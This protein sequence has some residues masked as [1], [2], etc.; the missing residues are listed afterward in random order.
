M[1]GVALLL[2]SLL[3]SALCTSN[4]LWTADVLTCADTDSSA[5]S[6]VPAEGFCLVVRGQ[7]QG[8][9]ITGTL[10][11]QGV[12]PT[13]VSLFSTSSVCAP[14]IGDIIE[15]KLPTDGSR[16]SRWRFPLAIP[17]EGA[18]TFHVRQIG[19]FD[20][21][22]FVDPLDITISVSTLHSGVFRASVIDEAATGA[23]T[24]LRV[25]GALAGTP[26]ISSGSESF[27][28][29]HPIAE[30]AKFD[31]MTPKGLPSSAVLIGTTEFNGGL[32]AVCEDGIYAAAAV[33]ILKTTSTGSWYK[34]PVLVDND[35]VFKRI[36][37]SAAQKHPSSPLASGLQLILGEIDGKE[38]VFSIVATSGSLGGFSVIAGCEDAQ[39][40]TMKDGL[41]IYPDGHV[42]NADVTDIYVEAS[43]TTVYVPSVPVV[44]P[45]L[46]LGTLTRQCENA[47]DVGANE[48]SC[49]QLPEGWSSVSVVDGLYVG[50]DRAFHVLVEGPANQFAV[51]SSSP[52]GGWLVLAHTAAQMAQCFGPTWGF[53]HASASFDAAV[54]A[55][56]TTVLSFTPLVLPATLETVEP[57]DHPFISNGGGTAVTYAH[58]S[59][60]PVSGLLHVGGPSAL[61]SVTKSIVT[62]MLH[63]ASM[64]LGRPAFD[65]L[66]QAV[67]VLGDGQ[68][69]GQ[70]VASFNPAGITGDVLL[71]DVGGTR[72]LTLSA[73]QIVA[74]AFLSTQ[75]LVEGLSLDSCQLISF[76]TEPIMASR[77]TRL[78]GGISYH[79]P[80]SLFLSSGDTLSINTLVEYD[81]DYLL[82]LGRSPVGQVEV[83]V[84]ALAPSVR[85]SSVDALTVDTFAASSDTR[86]STE[87]ALRA[88][89]IAKLMTGDHLTHLE[90][91]VSAHMIA[92]IF[93]PA[94][95]VPVAV[96]LSLYRE[97][98]SMQVPSV[99][100][101]VFAGC[102]PLQ[103]LFLS[104]TSGGVDVPAGTSITA[105]V[106]EVQGAVVPAD[107]STLPYI[108]AFYSSEFYPQFEVVDLLSGVSSP[109]TGKVAIEL[110]GAGETLGGIRSLT[111]RQ[112]TLHNAGGAYPMITGPYGDDGIAVVNPG[113]SVSWDCGSGTLCANLVATGTYGPNFFV[114]IRA[115]FV[116]DE[117]STCAF[118]QTFTIRL[119]AVSLSARF[120]IGL[121]FGTTLLILLGVYIGHVIAVRR[122]MK[123]APLS[124]E[125]LAGAEV[126]DI[127]AAV[128]A[129]FTAEPVPP[130]PITRPSFFERIRNR[131]RGPVPDI[132]M[133]NPA[134]ID[135]PAALAA[136]RVRQASHM[137]DMEQLPGQADQG[138]VTAS[139]ISAPYE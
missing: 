37:G 135:D 132:D 128:E 98:C 32:L 83:P 104:S 108:D 100:V 30:G 80:P 58:I 124:A 63:P 34:I 92:H 131:L 13:V 48:T 26:V 9:D 66:S 47:L 69:F 20:D 28:L 73:G 121:C 125:T 4:A 43:N 16:T 15:D 110:V 56:L 115:S 35:V 127:G 93:E 99:P 68:V 138:S 103:S 76:D 52:V 44:A 94:A 67:F 106:E 11:A 114:R 117:D 90:S 122:M 137:A 50:S 29:S 21:S 7:F 42:A 78:P 84:S 54:A 46:G 86:V 109:F 133:V 81:P 118:E 55:A 31:A 23:L 19:F 95:A 116:Q 111:A 2:L 51:L 123:L 53:G 61:V 75:S 49:V 60:S 3:A 17:C 57:G 39:L 85:L 129:A 87:Y 18:F 134:I 45:V 8:T 36:L 40:F 65:M 24:D 72:V 101:M 97:A 14:S 112:H 77:F 62:V 22:T 74:G 119:V 59:A 71:T 27:L 33:P 10:A 64:T 130:P 41:L 139:T 102:L 5:V 89:T 105:G 70:I 82:E 88:S 6:P 91:T 136:L 126:A 120:T 79:V 25:F 107:V 1:R 113:E 38:V 96:T 12:I